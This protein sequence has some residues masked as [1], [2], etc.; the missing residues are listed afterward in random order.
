MAK[1]QFKKFDQYVREASRKPFDL[2]VSDEETITI[3]PPTSDQMVKVGRALRDGDGHAAMVAMCGGSWERV[4]ALVQDVDN[5]V[6][7]AITRDMMRHFDLIEEITLV[8]PSGGE[9][10]TD[11]PRHIRGLI[12]KGYEVKGEDHASR[13]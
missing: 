5:A 13:P 6:T 1:S 3:S 2:P 11:D 4:W 9:V 12:A 10:T 8:G 7:D